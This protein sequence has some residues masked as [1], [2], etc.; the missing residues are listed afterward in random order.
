M[1]TMIHGFQNRKILTNDKSTRAYSK[2][3]TRIIL[4]R[5]KKVIFNKWESNFSHTINTLK[6]HKQPERYVQMKH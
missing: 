5:H 1:A 3:K 4:Y 2:I 6:I